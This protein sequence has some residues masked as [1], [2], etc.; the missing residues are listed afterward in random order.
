MTCGIHLWQGVFHCLSWLA[1]QFGGRN[2]FRKFAEKYWKHDTGWNT[3]AL[4]KID[5]IT[6]KVKGLC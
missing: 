3:K 4:L 1:L 5:Y 6:K 2:P